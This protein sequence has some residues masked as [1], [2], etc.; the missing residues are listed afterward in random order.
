MTIRYDHASQTFHLQS[1]STSYIIQVHPDGFL[2]RAVSQLK[3]HRE[4]AARRV[5][6]HHELRVPG[7]LAE[8][9]EHL[10]CA[11]QHFV[12]AER[13]VAQEQRA[14]DIEHQSSDFR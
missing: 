9:V 2:R 5:D 1:E 6:Q 11:R 13:P 7:P 12:A 8:R 3:G 4:L 10:D 14:V